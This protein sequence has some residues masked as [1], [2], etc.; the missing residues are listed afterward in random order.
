MQLLSGS[1]EHSHPSSVH[2]LSASRVD[3]SRRFHISLK[4][5]PPNSLLITDLDCFWIV[6]SAPSTTSSP[7]HVPAPMDSFA[8]HSYV[9]CH[10]RMSSLKYDSHTICSQCRDVVRSFS[11][12]CDECSNWSAEIMSDYL[13]HKKALATKSRKRPA[14]SASA[15]IQPAVASNPLLGSPL[16]YPQLATM[17]KLGILFYRY[18]LSQMKCLRSMTGVSWL[19]RVRN[20]VVRARTGVRRELA[21]RV[22]MNVLRWFGHVERNG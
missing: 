21:A 8:L 5:Y 11:T 9:K 13:K 19:D 7:A 2:L 4:F 1:V 16:G 3:L 10:R 14:T 20:E 17:I 6:A 15:S 22:D 12:C 18:A